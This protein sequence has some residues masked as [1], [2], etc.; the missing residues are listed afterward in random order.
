[1]SEK[2]VPGS[3]ALGCLAVPSLCLQFQPRS[4][5]IG[6]ENIHQH[7]SYIDDFS[8]FCSSSG[9]WKKGSIRERRTLASGQVCTIYGT[10][11]VDTGKMG[12]I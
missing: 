12:N 3:A 9:F 7:R 11:H 4:E 8:V 10:G 1:M 6:P 2:E 5:R